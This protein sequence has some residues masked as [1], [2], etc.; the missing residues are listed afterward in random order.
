MII[1]IYSYELL[2]LVV[3]LVDILGMK[4]SLW[5]GLSPIKQL[6]ITKPFAHSY[7][8][9]LLS[10]LS[11]ILK[12]YFAFWIVGYCQF[13]TKGKL[14]WLFVDDDLCLLKM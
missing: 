13:C 3:C 14:T 9:G 7:T 12:I 5:P 2:G 1:F 8:T 10:V 11:E 4:Q 6:G